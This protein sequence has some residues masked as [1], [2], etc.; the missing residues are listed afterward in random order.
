[1]AKIIPEDIVGA[2]TYHAATGGIY[3][4][5]GRLC[6]A[7]V[8]R[9]DYLKVSFAGKEYVQHR[10]AWFLYH[11]EQPPEQ[12]DHHN[13]NGLDNSISNLR[14]ADNSTNQMNIGVTSKSTTGI[15]GIFPIRG[16]KLYRA[17]VCI[18]GK[19]YQKCSADPAKL[20]QWVIDKRAELHGQYACN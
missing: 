15:K 14:P 17:E 1:M 8:T 13:G 19:R 4:Q 7:K 10:V 9:G 11:G 3:N 20:E 6:V 12:I 18:D 2:Y 16:G 5:S